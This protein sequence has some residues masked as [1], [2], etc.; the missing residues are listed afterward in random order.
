M[1]L[2]PKRLQAIDVF[3]AITMFFMIFVND[4]DGVGNI[5]SWIGHTEAR[6]D[7]MGFADTIFPAFLFIVGLSLPF[8][9]NNRL[10]K[11]HSVGKVLLYIIIRSVALIIMG[12][13]HVNLENYSD[14]A[15][16]SR[17]LW[18]LGI[19]IAFFLIWLDYPA[20]MGKAKRYT[21]TGAGIL[22][23][24]AMAW[25]YKGGDAKNPGGMQPHWWGILGIIGWAYMVCALVYLVIKGKL[26]LLIAVLSLFLAINILAHTHSLPFNIPILGDASSATLIMAGTVIGHI[27]G[28]LSANK[29]YQ[30]LWMLFAL[31]GVLMIAAG[32]I[33][34]PYA[35]GISKIMATPAWVLICAGISTLVFEGMIW[36]TDIKTKQNWFRVIRPAGTSTLTCYLI[37]YILYAVYTLAGFHYPSFLNEGI[38]GIFR[39]FAVALLVILIA[40]WLEKRRIRLKI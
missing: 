14:A 26:W 9:I 15:M 5:P 34:R 2:L 3:R 19:T 32:F 23:L 21:L 13:F 17:P 12:F 31:A 16:L 35:G 27:Y 7:G 30:R 6:E 37:P 11:G 4:V 29:T 24:L 33:L 10:S 22:L 18:A 39:S 40:G 20:D 38:G 25:M 36:L 28:K 1:M 8:A